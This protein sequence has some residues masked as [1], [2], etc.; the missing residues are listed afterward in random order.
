MSKPLI[1]RLDIAGAPVRWIP[2][3]DAV[4]LYSRELIAWTAG[5]SAFTFYGGIGRHTGER[6]SV[7]VNSISA[8][9][10]SKR[11]QY[12]RRHIPPLNNHELFRR[13][14]R[15]CM[16]CGREY[17]EYKMTRDHVVPLSQGGHDVWS[18]VVSA[19]RPCN[20]HKGGRTPEQAHMSLLAI[21]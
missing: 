4:C 2:W 12:S 3:R 13:D 8:L 15:L 9:K 21:P 19:C 14:G 6:S 1:L 18:Y 17:P 11:E 5:E 10:H 20:T 7:T 16:Y